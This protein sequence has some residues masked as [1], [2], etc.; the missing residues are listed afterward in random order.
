MIPGNLGRAADAE[1]AFGKIVAIGLAT[2]NLAVKFLFRPG[3]IEFWADTKISGPYPIWLRQLAQ[4]MVATRSCL[5]VI[6][7]TSRTGSEPLNERLSLR[8]AGG[9][10][11]GAPPPP[12]GGGRPTARPR[13]RPP[14]T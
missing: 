11:H 4:Q 6:G 12:R 8:R 5:R 7:H 14:G 10:K 3:S 2:N 9:A 13:P 1:N